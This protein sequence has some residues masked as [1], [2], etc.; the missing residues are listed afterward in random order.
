M[1]FEEKRWSRSTSRLVS[2]SKG[3]E[4]IKGYDLKT[5]RLPAK[6]VLWINNKTS[7]AEQNPLVS[8]Q[9]VLWIHICQDAAVLDVSVSM[10]VFYLRK[11]TNIRQ[12]TNKYIKC[13]HKGTPGLREYVILFFSS[14]GENICKCPFKALQDRLSYA[15]CQK[16]NRPDLS[17]FCYSFSKKHTKISASEP[18]KDKKDLKQVFFACPKNYQI[19]PESYFPDRPPMVLYTQIEGKPDQKN[20]R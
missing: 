17:R 6:A 13:P 14:W 8:A 9:L 4:L 1:N 11:L 10:A 20:N 15:K 3:I 19:C 12:Y 16:P 18:W 7:C 2:S 5:G